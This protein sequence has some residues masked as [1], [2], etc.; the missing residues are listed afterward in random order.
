MTTAIL[1]PY[2]SI[3][4]TN[5]EL[6]LVPDCFGSVEPFFLTRKRFRKEQTEDSWAK[7]LAFLDG[8]LK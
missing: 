4:P 7:L 8:K 5:N 6:T 2:Q 3:V 1:V